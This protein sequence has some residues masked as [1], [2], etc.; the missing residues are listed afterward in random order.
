MGRIKT[1]KPELKITYKI[2]NKTSLQ[3][4]LSWGQKEANFVAYKETKEGERKVDRLTT[5][6]QLQKKISEGAEERSDFMRY[7]PLYISTGYKA[8]DW[9]EDSKKLINSIKQKE[10]LQFIQRI[11]D[12]FEYCIEINNGEPPPPNSLRDYINKI[13]KRT[14]IENLPK[15]SAIKNKQENTFI[16]NGELNRKYFHN[17]RLTEY[18]DFKIK[19]W[20]ET[21]IKRSSTTRNHSGLIKFIKEF[22]KNVLKHPLLIKQI[23]EDILERFFNYIP[24]IK[25]YSIGYLNRIFRQFRMFGNVI[26]NEDKFPLNI[27]WKAKFFPRKVEDVVE[28]ALE[29]DELLKVH[30][31]Q[32]PAHKPSWERI[33]DLF[34]FG[35]LNGLRKSDLNAANIVEENKTLSVQQTMIKT[36]EQVKVPLHKIASGILEKYDNELPI[37]SDPKFN[38]E[39]KKICKEAGLIKKVKVY[40]TNTQNGDL[41]I[42]EFPM[43]NLIKSSTCRRT[44]ATLLVTK[45]GLSPIQA[46]A[47]TG[48]KNLTAFLKY[49]RISNE[50]SEN[51]LS[52]RFEME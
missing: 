15:Y 19:Y 23:K 39:I 31:Y 45:W 35:C 21:N 1:N 46:K 26:S 49:I 52:R 37:I 27:Y 10:L 18:M 34:I 4:K 50:A 29:W 2:A 25:P 40:R 6:M 8:R 11:R 47:Y 9:N 14:D 38:K 51:L 16:I 17:M 13:A 44:F 43:Y 41:N 28:V 33:K 22:E 48:H 7:K 24:T 32:V 36:R 20:K 12:A 42:T 30:D 3:L 5:G